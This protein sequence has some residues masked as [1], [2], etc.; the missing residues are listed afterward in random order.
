MG[1]SFCNQNEDNW[2]LTAFPVVKYDPTNRNE[3]GHYLVDEWTDFSDIGK[4]FGGKLFSYKDYLDIE[5]K[6]IE[7]IIYMFNSNG[8]K[9]IRMKSIRIFNMPN[10]ER[11]FDLQLKSS[12]HRIIKKRVLNLDEVVLAA[13]LILRGVFIA[14]LHCVN[15]KE[16]A[17]RF[18]YDYYVYFNTPDQIGIREFIETE[19]GLFTRIY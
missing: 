17:V 1:S 19:L 6:I 3:N 10:L 4:V 7:A 2:R 14:E 15:N 11:L 16:I 18:D 9:K 12:F 13:R 5:N 8:C